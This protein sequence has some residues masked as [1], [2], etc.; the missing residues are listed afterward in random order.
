MAHYLDVHAPGEP[1]R[2][3]AFDRA[4]A[5]VGS[6]SEGRLEASGERTN[7]RAEVEFFPEPDCVR[8]VKARHDELRLVFHGSEGS[9]LR[10][11]WGDEVFLDDVRLVFVSVASEPGKHRLALLGGAVVLALGAMLLLPN[12]ATSS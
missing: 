12:G 11:P 6:A 4:L 3:R 10:V 8:V 2:R 7:G 9:T 1:P 5:W